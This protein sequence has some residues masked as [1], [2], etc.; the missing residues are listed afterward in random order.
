MMNKSNTSYKSVLD[1]FL[2]TEYSNKQFYEKV[3]DSF[4]DRIIDLILSFPTNYIE[5]KVIKEKIETKHLNNFYTIDLTVIS[6]SEFISNKIPF[7]IN[8]IND[9]N[10]KVKIVFFNLF[11][12]FLKNIYKIGKKYRITGNI[13]YYK[14]NIQVIHP[15]SSFKIE[16]LEDFEEVEPIY[17][18]NKKKIN[19]KRFR[20]LIK[21]NILFF[22]KIEIPS[23]W[24]NENLIRKFSWRNFKDCIIKIHYND[25]KINKKEIE[26]IRRRLAFDEILSNL[27]IT[28]RLKKTLSQTKSHFVCKRKNIC[29]EI[30]DNLCFKLTKDQ[31][32]SYDDICSDMKSNKKMFRLLQG[33]V[34]SGKTIISALAIANAI[35]SGYQAA[36]MVPT[37]ILAQQH[38][39]Y[40][41]E[42]FSKYKINTVLLTG[43]L[44]IKEKNEIYIKI[45]NKT[46][47]LVVGTHSL[48]NKNIKF[49]SLGLTV[50]DEQHKFGVNQRLS[51]Q[52]KSPNCHVLI[53]SATPIPR[54]LTFAVYG[55][56]DISVIREKPK[57]RKE[58]KTTVISNKKIIELYR[59]I[60]RKVTNNEKV[61]WVVPEIGKIG[62]NIEDQDINKE[63]ILTRYSSLEKL[64]GNKVSF[65]HGKMKKSEINEKIEL[66]KNDNIMILIATT[67]IEV[68]IDIPKASLI[69]IENANNFGLA[70]LHQLRGRIGRGKLQADCVLVHNNN[71]SANG[72]SRLLIMKESNDGF[73]IAEQDLLLR[74]GGEIFG[75]KQTGL[76][77]W[78]FF[79]PFY[80]MDLLNDAKKNSLKL[81]S[82]KENQQNQVDFLTKVFFKKTS[83][84]NYFT[85]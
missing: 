35:D 67:V 11:P 72:K 46:V 7:S 28:S 31:I 18:L 51:L 83:I 42:I 48:Y 15:E 76:P 60:G 80:D 49:S 4:G 14:G 55:E 1:K 41:K 13:E 82:S 61:F 74:G 32:N 43:K 34:G 24:I 69:V 70:Q 75:T 85:G 73:L 26:Q 25:L 20:D 59:G 6:Y 57:G 2:K 65:V 5:R 39:K 62:G 54:S 27:L 9:F 84:Q 36:M 45:K 77:T 30:I 21:K 64:F 29:Q 19:K 33:D 40:F 3:K 63:S 52:S 71:L 81:L 56:I 44:T 47:D 17:K 58:I 38:Y 8:C 22:Q 23:E 66:F 16:N 10:Q 68:G 53:M 12:N 79:N 50:I 37:E 78:K